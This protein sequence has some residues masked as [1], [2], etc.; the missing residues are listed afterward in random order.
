MKGHPEG[1]IRRFHFYGAWR[2]G[3]WKKSR[4]HGYNI[5]FEAATSMALHSEGLWEN[6]IFKQ[7]IFKGEKR[8]LPIIEYKLEESFAQKPTIE[9]SY[10][11]TK[12]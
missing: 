3:Y 2:W 5:S 1:F 10:Y 11:F 12:F 8:N 7:G 9:P 4:L 6:D